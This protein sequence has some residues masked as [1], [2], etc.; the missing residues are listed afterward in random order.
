MRGHS[1]NTIAIYPRN[2][3]QIHPSYILRISKILNS[4]LGV[5]G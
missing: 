1:Q 2:K 4:N 5:I 3:I